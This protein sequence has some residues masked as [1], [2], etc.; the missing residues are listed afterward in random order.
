MLFTVN[1]FFR[2]REIKY[3]D[4]GTFS[5]SMNSTEKFPGMGETNLG[6]D[7]YDEGPEIVTDFPKSPEIIEMEF[8][9]DELDPKNL[10]KGPFIRYN[11]KNYSKNN[12]SLNHRSV[13]E[14][15]QNGMDVYF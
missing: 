13:N 11:V 6:Y 5:D 1:V 4:D 14:P 10:T 9:Q 7:A 8:S 12:G 15:K 2:S 3:P